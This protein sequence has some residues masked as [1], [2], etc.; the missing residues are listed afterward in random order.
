MIQYKRPGT[1][2]DPILLNAWGHLLKAKLVLTETTHNPFI[3]PLKLDIR[4]V[5]AP[6]PP[7][8]ESAISS[9]EDPLIIDASQYTLQDTHPINKFIDTK[10]TFS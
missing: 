5:T 9:H 6:T 8:I 1:V 7:R 2:T 3:A 10:R 4:S